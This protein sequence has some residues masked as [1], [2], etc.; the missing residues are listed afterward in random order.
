MTE[1]KI[2]N[3]IL[4][5]YSK[6]SL[7]RTVKEE[8]RRAQ[9]VAATI[10]SLA[11]LGYVNTSLSQI[12]KRA[13]ISTSLILYHFKD[14]DELILYT[15][16]DISAKWLIAIQSA[17]QKQTDPAAKLHAY[18]CASLAFMI[19]R[20]AFMSARI[21]IIFNTRG[22]DGRLYFQTESYDHTIAILLQILEEGRRQQIFGDVPM[23]SMAMIIRA[24][25]DQFLGLMKDKNFDSQAYTTETI[26][27]FDKA[28]K[29]L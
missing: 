5:M 18:I 17:T 4:N 22:S 3:N 9:I 8:G 14:K 11:E 15:L 1:N 21:E 19:E 6:N 12:A 20:P 2:D 16:E 24:S 13:S 25:I 28:L 27:I 26:A 23:N 7:Q 10:Y 29:P